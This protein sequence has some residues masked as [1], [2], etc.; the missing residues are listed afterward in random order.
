MVALLNIDRFIKIVGVLGVCDRINTELK[1]DN[2][3][4]LKVQPNG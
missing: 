1:A 2:N 3:I 4:T